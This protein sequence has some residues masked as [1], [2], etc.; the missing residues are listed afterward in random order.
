MELRRTLN[1]F[2][3]TS[4]GIWAIIGAGIVVVWALAISHAGPAVIVSMVI[5]GIVASFTAFSF[6]EL[7]SAV[8]KQGGVYEFA[9]EMVS[10][11]DIPNLVV[12]TS[13][14][15]LRRTISDQ[16]M[17]EQTITV[18]VTA[19]WEPCEGGSKEGAASSQDGRSWRLAFLKRIHTSAAPTM[20]SS[21]TPETTL[22]HHISTG[23]QGRILAS[24]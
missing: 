20:I 13:W 22:I 9:Y 18:P 8:P 11:L 10:P 17:K 6:A 12:R 5:A 4:I 23:E 14:Y 2:D 3:A 15:S 1:L 19:T 16:R 7:G 24:K 21:P